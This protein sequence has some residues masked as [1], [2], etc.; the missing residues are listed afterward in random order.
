MEFSSSENAPDIENERQGLIK[1]VRMIDDPKIM[2]LAKLLGY[3]IV[4]GP[5][6]ALK[7]VLGNIHKASKKADLEHIQRKIDRID[8]IEIN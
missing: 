5:E 6:E 7:K 2:K 3:A 1:E 4:E 8:E